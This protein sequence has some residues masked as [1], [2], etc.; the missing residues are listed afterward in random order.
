M[1]FDQF[2][3][4]VINCFV[5]VQVLRISAN[6]RY[7]DGNRWK[8]LIPS[9]LQNLRIL[10]VQF[11]FLI[12]TNDHQLPLDDQFQQFTS[13]FWIERQWFF[14]CRYYR[15]LYGDGDY[16]SFCSINPYRY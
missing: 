2:E 5:S 16:A 12:G 6:A 8:Q 3:Q 4:L 15:S 1:E 10:D 14:E 7:T 9:H 11:D 13:S